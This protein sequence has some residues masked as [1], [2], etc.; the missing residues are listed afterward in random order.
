MCFIFSK[1]PLI[2]NLKFK[3]FLNKMHIVLKIL[4]KSNNMDFLFF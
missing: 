4:K 1:L 2:V 3:E